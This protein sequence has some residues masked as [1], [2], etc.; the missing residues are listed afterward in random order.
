MD[1]LLI[2]IIMSLF[3]TA[4]SLKPSN[5]DDPSGGVK[6]ENGTFF[7]ISNLHEAGILDETDLIN[8]AYHNNY[9]IVF[10]QNGDSFE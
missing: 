1:K 10:D 7:S 5:T 2:L 6:L 9:G 8:S 4:C 3:M